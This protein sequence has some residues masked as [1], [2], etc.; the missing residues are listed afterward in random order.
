[1]SN[2]LGRSLPLPDKKKYKQHA[3]SNDIRKT[4]DGE[5]TPPLEKGA[6][7]ATG[8]TYQGQ[9]VKKVGKYFLTKTLGQG[10]FS[11][12]KLGIHETTEERVAVK[13]MKKQRLLQEGLIDQV[14]REISIMKLIKHP[15]VV[16]LYE[17]L[18]SA[19]N[20][21]LVME[22]ITGGEIFWKVATEKRLSESVARQYFHELVDALDYCHCHGVYHRDL[23]PENLLLD[24]AGHLKISDFGLSA[25]IRTD[26]NDGLLSPQ[27]KRKAE[28]TLLTTRCGTP[29][30]AAP[31]I[32]GKLVYFTIYIYNQK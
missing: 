31:E 12:V 8:L 9:E 23:K 11:K 15:N 26:A 20:L 21:Y 28:A 16:Q 1:M 24:A 6:S 19:A 17:V 2:P 5:S 10:A 14:K 18:S 3:T 25:Q 4:M 7:A 30:Y 32:L 22:L 13:I 29:Q 27:Q